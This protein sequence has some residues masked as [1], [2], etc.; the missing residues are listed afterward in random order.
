MVQLSWLL[1][2]EVGFMKKKFVYTVFAITLG[3]SMLM[4][5][6]KSKPTSIVPNEKPS[7]NTQVGD[8]AS[9][10]EDTSSQ[11]DYL[12]TTT[13]EEFLKNA[14]APLGTTLY[15]WGGGWNEAD[16]GAG[17]ETV[18]LGVSPRWKAFFDQNDASYDYDKTRFHIHDGLD[19]SGYLGWIIY[20]TFENEN[21]KAGYV[22]GSTD[23]ASTYAK[24][25]W[26]TFT[27]SENVTSWKA[28]DIMS[29]KGH[30]WIALGT[31]EDQS[32][33]L[34]HSSPPG[35]RLCG[36]LRYD[37]SDSMAVELARKY[38]KANYPE[39]DARY[40][41]YGVDRNYLERSS[42]MRW[43]EETFSDA[44]VFQAMTPEEIMEWLF[45]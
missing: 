37:G 41:S 23:M 11:I 1:K 8:S 27:S 14:K 29:M 44:K 36:T 10:E 38:T 43:N 31:C 7:K 9:I 19:C 16:D 35:V 33:L 15:V 22:M 4:G 26:G 17:E 40:P 20:N 34:M 45:E 21:G 18:T 5:C 42:Q 2:K 25:G 24:K 13:M 39:W 32:V 3:M 6:G 28:G 30:V 12:N